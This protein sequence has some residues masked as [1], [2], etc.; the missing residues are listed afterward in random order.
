MERCDDGRALNLL[1]VVHRAEAAAGRASGLAEA[2]VEK[3]AAREGPGSGLGHESPTA[4]RRE[5]EKSLG[6]LGVRF[7]EGHRDATFLIGNVALM[8]DGPAAASRATR[9]EPPR[10]LGRTLLRDRVLRLEGPRSRVALGSSTAAGAERAPRRAPRRR[11]RTFC[12]WR[13]ARSRSTR[14]GGAR[15]RPRSTA[16]GWAWAR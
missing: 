3:A 2:V 9:G 12:A 16:T 13:A 1:H 10:P 4:L 14:G 8:A 15:T 6:R 5:V 11:R 7:S